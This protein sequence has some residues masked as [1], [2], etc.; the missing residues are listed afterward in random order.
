MPMSLS[1]R[2]FAP[3]SCHPRYLHFY[4]C[5]PVPATPF[6]LH[7]RP[8]SHHHVVALALLVLRPILCAPTLSPFVSSSVR[9]VL[10]PPRPRSRTACCP[11]HAAP[12]TP[13]RP[14]SVACD[15]PHCA[16]SISRCVALG[17]LVFLPPPCARAHTLCPR[18]AAV[19]WP[20]LRLDV[21]D[22]GLHLAHI[23]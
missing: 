6:S 22:L 10:P 2:P 3:T 23:S 1:L 13:H 11:L 7:P 9:V 5:I 18:P 21:R 20:R 14:C 15:R 8:R 19:S 17:T 12:L 16:P 4:S